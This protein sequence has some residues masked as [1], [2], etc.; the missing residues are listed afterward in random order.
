MTKR[1]ADAVRFEGDEF[2]GKG[3]GAYRFIGPAD[4]PTGLHFNCPCGCGAMFGARLNPGGWT[5]DG[6][7]E[8]PTLTPSLGCYPTRGKASSIGMDG[9]YHWHGHLRAGVFEEC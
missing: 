2:L 3:P 6:N 4:A 8:A 7:R 1:N 5:W 9:V